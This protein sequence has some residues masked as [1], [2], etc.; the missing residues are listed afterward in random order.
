MATVR[1]MYD[2][3]LNPNDENRHDSA[4]ALLKGV[5]DVK[6]IIIMQSTGLRDRNGVEIFEGDIVRG[7][8]RYADDFGN[9]TEPELC[10]AEVKYG[11]RLGAVGLYVGSGMNFGEFPLEVIGNVWQ[12]P[13][14]L[15]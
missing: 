14:L 11:E 9:T 10:V 5:G 1:E 15:K 12:H 7:E 6:D 3:C 13:H 8:K 2:A 4:F